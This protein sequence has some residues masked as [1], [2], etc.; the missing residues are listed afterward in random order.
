MIGLK[1]SRHLLN[2]SDAKPKPIATWSHAFSRAWRRSRV[3]AT[4]SHWLESFTLV[5]VV[6]PKQYTLFMN[7]C[8]A[9]QG[10]QRNFLLLHY[11]ALQNN[12]IVGSLSVS[13][14]TAQSYGCFKF[15]TFV[16]EIKTYP[17]HKPRFHVCA[18][19]TNNE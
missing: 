13:C 9:R 15:K 14:L 2:Q 19:N 11:Q 7:G 17:P 5:V 4:S 8:P 3:F 10:F 18:K 12:V 16:W 6:K 1:Y